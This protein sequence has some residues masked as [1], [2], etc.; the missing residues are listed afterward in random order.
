MTVFAPGG[1]ARTFNYRRETSAMRFIRAAPALG[2]SKTLSKAQTAKLATRAT[3]EEGFAPVSA[4]R[5]RQYG[6]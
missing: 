4:V 5:P 2:R 1:K 3:V 6:S